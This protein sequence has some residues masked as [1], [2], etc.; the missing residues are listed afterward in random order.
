MSSIE[1]LQEQIHELQT[2]LAFQ[3]DTIEHLNRMV[4]KQ[5]DI[6]RALERRFMSLGEKI[7]DIRS[8]LPDKPFNPADEIPPHY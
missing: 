2:K 5:D 6:I 8:Q 7:D 4:T 3:E 1:E